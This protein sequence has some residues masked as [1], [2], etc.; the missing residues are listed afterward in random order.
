MAAETERWVS[1]KEVCIYLGVSR[2]TVKKMIKFQ[3]MPVCKLERKWKF[4]ISEI[5]EWMHK[6]NSITDEE[7][8]AMFSAKDN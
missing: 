6:E 3:N 4:K 5:D 1:M 2:D 7:R 8:E